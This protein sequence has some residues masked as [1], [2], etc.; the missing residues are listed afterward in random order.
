MIEKKKHHQSL[1]LRGV[2]IPQ[3]NSEEMRKVTHGLKGLFASEIN[4]LLSKFEP[5]NREWKEWQ[6]FERPCEEAIHHLRAR[7]ITAIGRD[8]QCLY[9]EKRI[10]PALQAAREQEAETMIG[11]QTARRELERL[12]D[13]LHGNT[14][15]GQEGGER[16][17]DTMA[18]RMKGR[19]TKRIARLLQIRPAETFR[20]YFGT[21]DRR[22]MWEELNTSQDH[23]ERTIEWL[24][25]MIATCM[26]TELKGGNARTGTEGA[27]CRPYVEEHCSE[28]VYRDATVPAL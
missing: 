3:L 25:A 26:G 9:G 6:A 28:E 22:A 13:L 14:D 5:K 21:H 27:R 1:M 16:A 2:N 20:G 18:E 23:T 19:F 8:P 11:A 7:V 10:N 15:P 12:K 17:D 4:R 24:D